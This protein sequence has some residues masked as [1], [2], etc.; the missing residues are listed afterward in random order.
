MIP[1][2]A[3][4]VSLTEDSFS[5]CRDSIVYVQLY[6]PLRMVLAPYLCYANA[7]ELSV[8]IVVLQAVE[9]I[10]LSIKVNYLFWNRTL[11]N[12]IVAAE[13][14]VLLASITK[15]YDMEFLLRTEFQVGAIHL[16]PFINQ[17]FKIILYYDDYFRI[18]IG[19]PFST[20]S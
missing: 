8:P 3:I 6:F 7:W 1:T 10:I 17:C 9:T 15:L 2:E 4:C 19:R 11:C 13:F 14:I 20:I 5:F 18:S 16:G 12:L